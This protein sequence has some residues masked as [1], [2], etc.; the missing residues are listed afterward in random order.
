MITTTI[1]LGAILVGSLIAIVGYLIQ[2]QLAT[3]I[4]RLDQHDGTIAELIKDVAHLAAV[5]GM[6]QQEAQ[7]PSLRRGDY[8]QAPERT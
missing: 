7:H 3:L 1:D 2:H 4:K 8:R 6:R 5:V